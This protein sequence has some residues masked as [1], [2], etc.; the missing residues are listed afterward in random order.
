MGF[1]LSSLFRWK[2][3]MTFTAMVLKFNGDFHRELDFLICGLS[4][5][6]M[7][8]GYIGSAAKRRNGNSQ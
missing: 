3:K 1:P 8:I 5:S 2:W 4:Q 6:P 7:F